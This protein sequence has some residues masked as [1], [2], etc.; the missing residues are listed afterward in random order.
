MWR[1]ILIMCMALGLGVE[2]AWAQ[3]GKPEATPLSKDEY[4]A[5]RALVDA[6]RLSEGVYADVIIAADAVDL[7]RAQNRFDEAR[8]IYL[9]ICTNTDMPRDQRARTCHVLGDIYRRGWGVEQDYTRAQLHYEWACLTGNHIPACMQ[10]A[11][12]A[13]TE[14]DGETDFPYA[15]H[16]Y[17]HACSLNHPAACA[18]LGNMLYAGLG[19]RKDRREGLA[20]MQRACKAENEWA[21]ERLITYGCLNAGSSYTTPDCQLMTGRR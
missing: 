7:R 10:L 3:F 19:G 14:H 2:T 9:E 11:Y 15:R 5:E 17:T 4:Y 16:V 1:Q 13:H 8:L 20:L 12:T 6:G 18:G 21:C